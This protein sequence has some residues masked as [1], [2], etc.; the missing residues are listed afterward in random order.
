MSTSQKPLSSLGS[1]LTRAALALLAAGAVISASGAARAQED[2]NPPLPNVMLLVD[3]SGSME[4]QSSSTSFPTC[5]PTGSTPSQKSRWIELLEVLTGSIQ[6]Y[7]CDTVDRNSAAFLNEYSLKGTPPPDYQYMNP[8]HRPMSGDCTPGPGVL[9]YPN[10]YDFPDGAIAYHTY[11]STSQACA[12]PF[13]QANDGLLDSFETRVRFG[14]MTF[15]TEPDPSTGVSGTTPDYPGGIAGTWSYFVNQPHSGKPA[16]CS[17]LADM[18]VGARNAAAPPWEGRMVAFGDPDASGT[19]VETK[20]EQIQQ[21]LLATRPFGATPIAGL[22][23]DA[24]DFFWNDTSKDPMN[25]SLDFGPSNDPYVLGGCRKNY[26]VLLTDGEPNLDLRPYC[27]GDGPPKGVCPYQDTPE[28]V[29]FDLANAADPEKRIETF[30]IGFAVSSVTVNGTS[31]DCTKLSPSDIDPTNPTG[32]CAQNQSSSALQ[33]CCTLSRI[34]YNGGTNQAY[35]ANDIDSLRSAMSAVLSQISTSTSSRTLPVFA[36]SSNVNDPFAG[37]Y[38]F[39]SS[40]QPQPLDLWSGVLERQRYVCVPPNGGGTPTPQ[41]QPIDPIKGDDFVAN[42]DSGKGS[43]RT[44]YSVTPDVSGGSLRFS[45]HSIRPAL[46]SDVDGAGVY[47]GSEYNGQATDFDSETSPASMSIDGSTCASMSADQCRD[48]YLKW[49]LGLNNGTSYTRCATAGTSSCNLVGD[50]YHSTPQLVGRPSA[51]LRDQTYDIFSENEA[52]RP[53]VLYTSTN[54]GF[55]HAFEVAPN[56]PKATPINTEENNELWAFIP[57]AVLPSVPAE[58]PSTHQLLLDGQPVVRDVVAEKNGT[59]Y[60]F[61][62]AAAIDKDS[63]WRSVLVQ[64]FGASRGGYFALDVTDPVPD[65]ADPNTGPRF[66]WQLTEN[67]AGAPLFGTGGGTP[68]ITTLF[69]DPNGGNKPVEIPVAVLPGGSGGSPTGAKCN[70]K[71]PNTSNVDSQFPPRAQVNCYP[72]AGIG[73]RSLTIV[74]LDTGEIIRTFRQSTSDAPSGLAGR[75]TIAPI[76]SPITGQPVAYPG[77]TGAIADRIFVGDEDGTLWRVDVSSIDPSKWTMS[78]FF[79]A[80][81]GQA[82]NAGQPIDTQPVLSLDRLG[83]VTV[84]FSTGDQDVLTASGNNYVYSLTEKLSSDETTYTSSVNWYTELASGER[85]AGPMTLFNSGLY[86]SSF[87]PEPPGTNVC[88]AGSSRVWGVD[89]IT[90]D[91]PSDKSKGGAPRLPQNPSA[92]SSTLVQYLDD[93]S[94]LFQPGAEIF[95]VG[96]AQVP[97]CVSETTLPDPYFGSGSHTSV[98]GVNP[99]QFQLVMNTGST[100]QAISGGKSNVTTINLPTPVSAPHI[101]S[102]AAITQ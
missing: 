50:I 53:L 22:L 13:T 99:G 79:D 46:T 9:P 26:I 75:V 7:R 96:I 6:N 95:G 15:D 92:P 27:E 4:Y 23:D 30:V 8:Y 80:Y 44:F 41:A 91:D 64:G 33:A 56:D 16:G 65:A 68:L 60:T 57:P 52:T 85:V 84:A 38:R 25:S 100:G 20:N 34:A 2:V 97:T 40:F 54:D 18:E 29:A 102:W 72:S 19:A 78:L 42:V 83:N 94:S 82:F 90:P 61:Q 45:E 28:Q 81:S 73:A 55:L 71:D 59:S 39:F 31:V 67:T 86:F 17:T 11:E 47:G 62:R 32:L 49:L 87:K 37:S 48:K 66:L 14:L 36:S 24:R 12:V 70:R 74:R 51:L 10:A 89:Y 63:T 101:D 88:S 35:F 5:D 98:T 69:F 76:D 1:T 58:Y 77:D 43:P 21:I 93:S 3:T